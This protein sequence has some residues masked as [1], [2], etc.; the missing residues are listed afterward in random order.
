MLS[1]LIPTFNY[2]TLPL[3]EALHWQAV[4]ESIEFE[5]IVSDDAS[6]D[7]D[8]QQMN[9]AINLI[10]N[11]SFFVNSE[12]LGRGKNR[13]LLLSKAQ[14]SWILL[15]DCDTMPRDAFFIKNYLDA[16][17]SKSGR[18]FFG[19]IIY[20]NKIPKD[21]EMLRWVYGTKRESI[22]IQ[23]RKKEPHRFALI[24]NMLLQKELLLAY[25]FH[26]E[27]YEYG[28]EDIVFI[29]ELKKNNIEIGHVEN[30]TFHLN[31]EKSSTFLE[32]YHSSL[33]NLKFLIDSKIISTSDT[34]F[35]KFYEKIKRY[36]VESLV[37]VGFKIFETKFTKNLLSKNPSLLVFDLYRLGYFC[38]INKR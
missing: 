4:K 18:A 15:M 7:L 21:E 2:N 17:K 26:S 38:K 32:K 24:S 31:L 34:D 11:C 9:K 3:V 28:F 36:K 6:D 8:I 27:I 22:P 14:Y 12:N 20:E 16:I 30:P 23:I 33:R 10:P 35:T 37:V 5:I 29:L 19:G 13:N 1:I 25:P